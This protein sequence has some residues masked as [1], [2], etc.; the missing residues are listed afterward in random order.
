MARRVPRG[1][2]V[3]VG[4]LVIALDR[5]VAG[6]LAVAL[7]RHRGQLQKLGYAEPP[8]LAELET[9]AQ[10][11]AKSHQQSPGVSVMTVPDDDSSDR[12]FFTRSDISRRTG[13]SL[14]TVDRW[15]RTGALPSVKRGRTRRVSRADLNQFLAA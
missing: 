2:V 10:T 3:S 11:V 4:L 15:I 6:H 9:L 1:L 14:S 5:D 8:G 7:R 12:D 13:S